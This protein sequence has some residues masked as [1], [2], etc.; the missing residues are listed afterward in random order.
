MKLLPD[1]LTPTSIENIGYALDSLHKSP[2]VLYNVGMTTKQKST[3]KKS[4]A[5]S[6]IQRFK[7]VFSIFFW[8]GLIASFIVLLY[9]IGMMGAA[10]TDGAAAFG[11]SSLSIL[12]ILLIAPYLMILGGISAFIIAK[13]KESRR[14]IMAI[15]GLAM[16]V[17]GFLSFFILL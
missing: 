6:N 14:S 11:L 16:T 7:N 9:S 10:G 4:S 3:K 13:S 15:L 5:T 12:P 2:N 1:S 8:L 17:G